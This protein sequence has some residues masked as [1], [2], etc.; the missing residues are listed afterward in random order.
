MICFSILAL[1]SQRHRCMVMGEDL[2]TVP[3]EIVG[4]HKWRGL[5]LIKCLWFEK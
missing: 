1:E 2:G 3:V 5:L 4:K